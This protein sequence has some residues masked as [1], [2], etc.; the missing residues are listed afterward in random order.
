MSCKD[1]TWSFER[2]TTATL[3]KNTTA[4]LQLNHTSRCF[5]SGKVEFVLLQHQDMTTYDVPGSCI[6]K[7]VYYRTIRINNFQRKMWYIFFS[8]CGFCWFLHPMLLSHF[9]VQKLTLPPGRTEL[10]SLA[11]FSINS[12]SLTFG[13]THLDTTWCWW[14]SNPFISQI[15][16]CPAKL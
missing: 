15:L 16:H 6:Q 5:R 1:I 10:I 3:P 9:L 14:L 2:F 4:T 7:S 8:N 13:F 11:P 12:D